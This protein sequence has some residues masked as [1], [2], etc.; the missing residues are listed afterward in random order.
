MRE[1][2]ALPTVA[3]QGD[4]REVLSRYE[5]FTLGSL[6][7]IGL[8]LAYTLTAQD[9]VLLGETGGGALIIALT[10]VLASLGCSVLAILFRHSYAKWAMKASLVREEGERR[11]RSKLGLQYRRWMRR[12]LLAAA[13]LLAAGL[14][15]LAVGMWARFIGSM[16]A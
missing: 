8:G 16:H 1:E 9:A 7:L 13:V 14:A 3:P 10:T 6:Q 5:A 11:R 12:L 4:T 15:S 2:D